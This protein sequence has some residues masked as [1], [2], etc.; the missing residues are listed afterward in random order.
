MDK[1][2]YKTIALSLYTVTETIENII[3]TLDDNMQDQFYNMSA[4]PEDDDIRL[5]KEIREEA[6]NTHNTVM[7]LCK[8]ENKILKELR[9]KCIELSEIVFDEIDKLTDEEQDKIYNKDKR[10]NLSQ[11][12]GKIYILGILYETLN[13]SLICINMY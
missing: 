6:Y 7:S 1:K 12:D 5:L 8:R 10:D 13:E 4:V 3:D 2:D 11:S 9:D